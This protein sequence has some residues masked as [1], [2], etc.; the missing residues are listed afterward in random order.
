MD[1]EA[2]NGFVIPLSK[3]KIVLLLLGSLAFVGSGIWIWSVADN[4]THF[5]PFYIRAVAVAGVSFFGLCALYCSFKVFDTR[6]GL[7]IDNQGIV[8]NSSAVAAGRISWDEIVGVKVAEVS[9][10]RFITVE[11]ANP[12]RIVER[13]GFLSRLLNGESMK[14]TGSPINI[15]SNSLNVKFDTLLEGLT[16]AFEKYKGVGRTSG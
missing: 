9:G 14:M 16:K 11:V 3:A 4:Q 13:G 5:N 8:D 1:S 10:Q 6:P 15:S 2:P 12:E 7:I